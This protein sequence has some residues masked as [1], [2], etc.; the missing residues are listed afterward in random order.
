MT[1]TT[2]SLTPEVYDY[3]LSVSLREPDVLRELRER[4]ASMPMAGMQVSPDVGQFLGFLAELIRARK[5]LEVG[6]FTGYSSLQVAMALPED[7]ELIVCDVSE[8]YTTVARRYW[9][10]AGV[11]NKID[12]R[13]GPALAT[14]DDLIAVGHSGTFD[15][16]FIDADKT[17]YRVYV[18]RCL[19]LLRRG[20]LLCIDNVLWDGRTADPAKN[21]PDT[22]ALKQINSELH[23][24]ER[25]SLSM[26][27]IGDGL[28]LAIKR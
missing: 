17:S 14:L 19:Q 4:T 21:D 18:E 2:L 8:E 24:D 11:S 16:A 28:T 23:R 7:G 20:G 5:Y 9:E 13:L 6:V 25:I 12:L 1:D 3:L 27:A 15:L 10:Q 26:L 22:A